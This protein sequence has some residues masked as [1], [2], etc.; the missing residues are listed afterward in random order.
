MKGWLKTSFIDF[1]GHI[2][3]TFFYGS[4]NFRCKYCHN[5]DLVDNHMSLSEISEEKALDY[6]DKK[7]V[8]EGVC[9]TGGEPTL[10]PKII[11]IIKQ[12][13]SRNYLVKLDTNGSSFEVLNNLIENNLIDYV[14]LDIKASYGKYKELITGKHN[15]ERLINEVKKSVEYLKKQKKI[16][17]EFRSTLFP[18]YFTKEDLPEISEMVKDA[19]KYYLQQLDTTVTL[20]NIK[21]V[22]PFTIKEAEDVCRYF[23]NSVEE[24]EIR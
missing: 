4:C 18:P 23:K 11:D 19:K 7:K 9:I 3:S 20:E 13:K 1:P 10:N 14:A 8:Y 16:D 24:C 15:S 21:S 5:K 6:M 22:V 12:I 2:A 17:Y